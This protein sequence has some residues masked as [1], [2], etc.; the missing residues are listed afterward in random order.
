[1][2]SINI[3]PD[4]DEL[5]IPLDLRNGIYLVQLKSGKTIRFAQKLIIRR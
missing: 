1:V 4:V 2:A 5:T 3:D